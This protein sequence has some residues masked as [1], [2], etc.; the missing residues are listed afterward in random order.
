MTLLEIF[1]L[2]SIAIAYFWIMAF[3]K[4]SAK[5][6]RIENLLRQSEKGIPDQEQMQTMYE[7]DFPI[8]NQN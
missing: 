2:T 7:G 5:D 6:S 8:V 4:V 3:A 1:A